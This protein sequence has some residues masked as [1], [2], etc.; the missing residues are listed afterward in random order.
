MGEFDDAALMKAFGREG[1][2]VF[3]TP[4][5]LEAETLAQYGVR[6]ARPQRR[7]GGGV[8]RRVGGAAHHPPLRA[9][10]TDAARSALFSA[11]DQKR[12]CACR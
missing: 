4:T 2:G 12:S 10:I 8:L 1:R 5:V 6:G 3:M 11:S 9:A 7:A